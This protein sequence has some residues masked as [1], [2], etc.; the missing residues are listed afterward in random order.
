MTNPSSH[1][2]PGKAQQIAISG[3]TGMVGGALA[4]FL[5]S[6]GDEVAAISRS[7]NGPFSDTIVW[8]PESGLINPDR[9]NEIDTV[10]HLA[11]ESIAAARWSDKQ[12]A[13]IR[14]SRVIGTRN[15]I[16]SIAAVQNRPKTLVCASAI[17]YYGNR[18][19]EELTED[20][21]PGSGF[22]PEVS[23]EWEAEADAAQ[24]LGLRVVKVR[25][26]LVLS[27]RGGALQKM[28]FP[29]K[30]G[31]GGV[32]G[33]GSQFWSWIGLH[34]L[35]KILSEC[36]HNEAFCG[37]VNAVSPHPVTNHE[38]TKTLGSVLHRP[39]ILPIPRFLARIA[40]GEMADDLLFTSANVIPVKLQDWG[41]QFAHP[42][43]DACLRFELANH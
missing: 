41:F 14:D 21:A 16:Q 8:D 1:H 18:G 10:V 9:L 5:T 36:V 30:M 32:V 42:D 38:F 28:L 7:Q 27:P 24:E 17:G 11:G 3:A 35:V 12:K 6:Q 39:T 31:V 23:Q 33:S 37:P 25:I 2:S 43:L 19:D 26:G 4:D 40:M 20:S 34:D 15:L 29:F 13:K 22:L